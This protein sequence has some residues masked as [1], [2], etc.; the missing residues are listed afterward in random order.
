MDY[1]VVGVEWLQ[2]FASAIL[3]D[4]S[5][6]HLWMPEWYT[7]DMRFIHSHN[8]LFKSEVLLGKLEAVEFSV[9]PNPKGVWW[10]NG[11]NPHS[12][13]LHYVARLEYEKGESYEFGGPDRF[14]TVTHKGPVMTHY[15]KLATTIGQNSGFL[16]R[17]DQMKRTFEVHE[18]PSMDEIKEAFKNVMR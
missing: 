15:T 18:R 12:V 6:L 4:G 3:K 13:Y 16:V 5:A 11:E 14:H 8:H 17:R 1:E 9:K 2:G 7:T 10:F